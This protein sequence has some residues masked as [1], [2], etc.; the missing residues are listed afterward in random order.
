MNH[1]VQMNKMKKKYGFVILHYLAYDMTVECISKLLDKF[2]KYDMHIV[3]VDNASKNQS[4]KKLKEKYLKESLVTVI[5]NIENLGF[6]KGNNV[7]YQYL[8]DRYDMDYIIVMNNDILIEQKE[9][10]D[11]IDI[12]YLER[13]FDILGPDIFCP[14][15]QIHQNPS[16]EKGLTKEELLELHESKSRFLNHPMYYYFRHLIFGNIKRLLKRDQTER[17]PDYTKNSETSVLH[18]ACYIFSKNYIRSRK[19][20]FAPETFMY[21]EEDILSSQHHVLVFS[22][23]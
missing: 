3:I 16:R 18:G 4:G 12:I 5:E 14:K 10:L 6:A 7:G 20:C 22:N 11:L 23:K 21:M 2:K 19:N 15:I 9:F 8:I 1:D 13:P 17:R